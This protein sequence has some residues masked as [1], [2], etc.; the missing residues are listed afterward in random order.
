MSLCSL[1]CLLRKFCRAVRKSRSNAGEMKP[2]RIRENGVKI[3]QICRRAGNGR[4]G[5]VIHNV[6]RAHGGTR[7]QIVDAKAVSAAGDKL[8]SYIIFAHRRNRAVSDRIVRD[9][10]YKLCIISVIGKRYR[11][12]G[13]TSAIIDIKFI[14]LYKFFIA[15]GG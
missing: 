13:L 8:C 11:H 6:R 7:F 1:Q 12:I 14:C 10:S 15:R 5:T 4:S 3:E 9:C 2:V